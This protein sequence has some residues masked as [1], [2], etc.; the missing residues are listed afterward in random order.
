MKAL[1]GHP[2]PWHSCGMRILPVILFT[3]VPSLAHAAMTADEFDAYTKGKTFIYGAGGAPY[4]VEQY[5]D[6]RRVRWSFV[7]GECQEGEWYEEDG[8]ICFVYDTEPDPQC[9]S[10]EAGPNGLIARF[11]NDPTEVELYEAGQS[12]TPLIC[13]GP[14][15]GV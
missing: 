12:D 6:N 7:E 10:F 8:L 11:E 1:A 2:A 9:W 5:L 14:D 15:V 3:L 13:P 4:G